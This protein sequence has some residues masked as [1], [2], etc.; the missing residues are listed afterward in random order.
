MVEV[1]GIVPGYA[2]VEPGL[3][4]A[5]PPCAE[6]V[7]SALVVLAHPRHATVHALK[8]DSYLVNHNTP[9][10]WDYQS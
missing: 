2:A 8:M 7:G 6:L 5:G 10:F 3:E 1:E 9:R 4:V